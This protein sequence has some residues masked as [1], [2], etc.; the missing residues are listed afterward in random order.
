MGQIVIFYIIA[1]DA[2]TSVTMARALGPH[3]N[4]MKDGIFFITHISDGMEIIKYYLLKM[5]WC[6]VRKK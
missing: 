3:V 6:F 2:L 4:L 5:Y 1:D